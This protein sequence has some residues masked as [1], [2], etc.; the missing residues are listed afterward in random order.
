M[1]DVLILHGLEGS[2]LGHWQPWVASRLDGAALPEL[3]DPF[4]PV[5]GRWLQ[6][7]EA[8]VARLDEPVVLCH[9]LGCLLWLHFCAARSERAP[10]AAPRAARVLLV[11]PPSEAAGVQAI[12]DFFP[13]PLDP[14][15]V[16]GG[17]TGETRL[18]CAD[19][20]P[21]CPE[22]AALLYG[23]PLLL[24]TDV[25]PGG[26]HLNT[27]AGYGPWPAVE[28]WARGEAVDF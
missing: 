25:I 23:D 20:D 18:V 11:A 3:P 2:G 4:H 13:L 7:L 9:S 12:A 21:Y 24:P 8:E 16:A 17:A 26:G 27:D 22:G 6:V 1:G 10:E 28:A 19:D 15:A 5:R 14:A